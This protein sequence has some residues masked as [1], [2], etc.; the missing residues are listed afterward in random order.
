MSKIK[1]LIVEDEP[2]IAENISLYLDNNDFEV[3]G[4]AYDSEDA[5][6]QLKENT[7]DAVLLDINLESDTDG[8]DIARYIQEHYQLP[9]IFLTSYS[10]R[11]TLERAKQVKPS[12]YIVKPFNERTL[13]ASLE[14]AISNHAEEANHALP[15]LVM[16]KV[17]RQLHSP[18]SEREFELSQMIYEGKTNTQ[19]AET[20][21]IT[22]NTVKTH[23]KSIY[24][25][26]DAGTRIEV[27]RKL[28]QAMLR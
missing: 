14:I 24:L 22:V 18:L 28:Q 23:L 16:E 13:L 20:L 12:G 8:I 1:I 7:P 9:F 27:I 2:V 17:N 3:S 26:L 5:M 21:F 4:I 25:K 19:I 15:K 11:I 6:Q 10:D